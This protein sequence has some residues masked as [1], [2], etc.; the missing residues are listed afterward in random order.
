MCYHSG[1]GSI[2]KRVV[3]KKERINK[4]V[5]LLTNSMN[6][7]CFPVV[8]VCPRFSSVQSSLLSTE[9]SIF[10]KSSSDNYKALLLLIGCKFTV[11]SAFFEFSWS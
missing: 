3:G 9:G 6:K 11:P 5:V 4:K 1:P 10:K 8:L 2:H 7:T